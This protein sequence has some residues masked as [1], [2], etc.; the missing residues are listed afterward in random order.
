MEFAISYEAETNACSLYRFE[1]IMTF[2]VDCQYVYDV[3]DSLADKQNFFTHKCLTEIE[4]D[5]ELITD[6]CRCGFIR[7]KIATEIKSLLPVLSKVWLVS[8]TRNL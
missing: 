7:R 3:P 2:T 8:S 5:D 1:T 6:P 4:E